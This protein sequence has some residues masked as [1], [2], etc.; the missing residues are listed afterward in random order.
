LAA[1]IMAGAIILLAP[2]LYTYL[3]TGL[4]PRFPTLIVGAAMFA[5][6]FSCLAIGLLLKEITNNRYESRYLRYLSFPTG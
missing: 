1:V 4:V 3:L 6:S 5:I 2:L